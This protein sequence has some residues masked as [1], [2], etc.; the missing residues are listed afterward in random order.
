MSTGL[1]ATI[2]VFVLVGLFALIILYDRKK[3]SEDVAPKAAPGPKLSP[4]QMWDKHI[5]ELRERGA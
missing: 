4:T 2:V 3:P 1:M 5:D